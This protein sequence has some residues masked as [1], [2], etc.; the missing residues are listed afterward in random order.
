MDFSDLK[1][2]VMGVDGESPAKAAKCEMLLRGGNKNTLIT[3]CTI[4]M[5]SI[6]ESIRSWSSD[7]REPQAR[8]ISFTHYFY[9]NITPRAVGLLEVLFS[10]KST[11]KQTHN[12]IPEVRKAVRHKHR[13]RPKRR[14]P[15]YDG[16]ICLF[17][18]CGWLM[19]KR[20]VSTMIIMNHEHVSIGSGRF[21]QIQVI[22]LE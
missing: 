20:G 6:Y 9:W 19:I 5:R 11:F 15:V 13:W 21:S 1:E 7:M 4:V 14:T 16:M 22:K 12:F 3:I 18:I 8:T 17:S 2:V 10:F